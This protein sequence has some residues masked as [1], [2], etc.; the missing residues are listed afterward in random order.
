M[1]RVVS[2]CCPGHTNSLLCCRILIARSGSSCCG[3]SRSSN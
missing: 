1:L 3:G 2:L